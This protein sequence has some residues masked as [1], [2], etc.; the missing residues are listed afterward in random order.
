MSLNRLATLGRVEGQRNG[1]ALLSRGQGAQFDD[2]VFGQG[3]GGLP[4]GRE[5]LLHTLAAEEPDQVL[6]GQRRAAVAMQTEADRRQ[7][8]PSVAA[9]AFRSRSRKEPTSAG[10]G[11]RNVALG[12]AGQRG[13]RVVGSQQ[14]SPSSNRNRSVEMVTRAFA[15]AQ[16]GRH[17]PGATLTASLRAAASQPRGAVSPSLS[18][19]AIRQ[20][21]L[22][23][24]TLLASFALVRE[25]LT[26]ARSRRRWRHHVQADR[27][28]YSLGARADAKFRAGVTNVVIDGP[29]RD[30]KGPCYGR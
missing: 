13:Q 3:Q 27:E 18:S 23:K 26:S 14:G 19:F 4:K 6:S 5:H 8:E 22:R 2:G 12:G 30:P 29:A 17:A 7:Q 9:G 15:R 1:H 16:H 21:C 11:G 20:D 10:V 25:G 28:R 24:T